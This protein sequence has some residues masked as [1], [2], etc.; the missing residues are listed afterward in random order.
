VAHLLFSPNLA[1]AVAVN[2]F[3]FFLNLLNQI[4]SSSISFWLQV[5][6]ITFVFLF[7]F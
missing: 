1:A 3:G 6:E 7:S 2:L 5:K 4:D